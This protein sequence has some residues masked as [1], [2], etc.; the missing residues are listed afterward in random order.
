MTIIS[1]LLFNA[2]L[3]AQGAVVVGPD[4][5][6]QRLTFLGLSAEGIRVVDR[7]GKMKTLPADRVLR[8]SFNHTV[9]M[10][11]PKDAVVLK[12]VDGQALVGQWVGPG[13]D[14]ESIRLSLSAL[15]KEVDIPLD[16]VVSAAL[17]NDAS[18]APD[19]EDDTLL[20]AS[21]ETLTGFLEAVKMD[22]ID[23]VVGDADDPIAIPLDRVHGFTI[24]NKPKP[25]KQKAEDRF[26]RVALQDGSSYLLKSAETANAENLGHLRLTGVSILPIPVPVV[27]LAMQRVTRIEPLSSGQVLQPLTDFDDEVLE[28]GE[29]F[30][31]PKPPEQTGDGS[32]KLHAPVKLGFDLPSGA[33]RVAFTVE[34]DLGPDISATHRAMAGCELI[35]Y[36]GEKL[37]GRATLSPD[38]AAQ[39]INL[40]LTSSALRIALKPGV[41]GPV[42]DRVLLTDAQVVVQSQ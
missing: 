5:N 16:D 20:L 6:P 10:P 27:S 28:G 26:I 17:N 35:V 3:S 37:L 11:A 2:P 34:M 39:R 19:Q 36:E 13:D 30:G 40:P 42:L 38:T 29:V 24:A 23:F 7:L 18:L 33:S 15:K 8:L 31:V 14:G 12:L 21:G 41:N 22:T 9:K 32:L 4:L 1:A 25:I